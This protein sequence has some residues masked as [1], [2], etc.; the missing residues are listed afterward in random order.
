MLGQ[1]SNRRPNPSRKTV[2][3]IDRCEATR[4]VRAAVLQTHGIEVHAVADLRGA[5]L[6]WK[7]NA[8]SWIFLDVRGTFPAR[9]S[10]STSRSKKRVLENVSRFAYL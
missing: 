6:L 9:H 1:S 10:N 2:L 8:Y 4:E 3:L 7:P 5:R